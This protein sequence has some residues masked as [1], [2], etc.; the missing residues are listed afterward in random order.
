[1]NI[2]LRYGKRGLPLTLASEWNAIIIRKPVMPVLDDPSLAVRTA[3]TQPVGSG[4]IAEEGVGC[5]T[6]CIAV[7]DITRPVPNS[8]FL[9]HLLRELIAVG[10]KPQN[11]LLLIATGLHRPS[12]PA[13]LAQIIGD[14]WILDTFPIADHYARRDED[15]VLLGVTSRGTPT[16]ID[17]R[18]VE[19]DL[20]IVTGLVEPHLMAGY[21]GGRKVISPGLCHADTI[22]AL[23][24]A[25][26]MG[27]PKSA[28]CIL[29]DNPLHQDQLEILAMVGKTL[30]INTVIDEE[31]RL[32]LVNF[33]E[34]QTSHH[35]AVEYMRPYAEVPV[36]RKFHT[37]VTTTAGYPL[38]CN[39]YQ[40]PKG[41]TAGA[42]I[43]APGGTLLVASE[44][45]EGLG[46][47]EFIAA[48][49]R[50]SEQGREAFLRDIM[51]K[52]RADI[53]EWGTQMIL[54]AV[55][56]GK[57]GLYSDQLSDEDMS[58]TGAFRVTSME[59]AIQES[60][61]ASGD[62]HVAIIPEGPYVVPMV[63]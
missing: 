43:L 13:E 47:E 54:K 53:D 55:Q 34:A 59:S 52:P 61:D 58:L 28:L 23:H 26:L 8:L 6:A 49:R 48:Q 27:H 60:I 41:I 1:M 32:S 15:H 33:G 63:L 16:R 4:T 45:I 30:A 31:R 21:S 40:T 24:R 17:K 20:R 14:P 7:C 18:F 44:C 62:P 29:Q 12:T 36:D 46:S 57:I 9:P 10:L 25:E 19:A 38:D 5:Q 39:Y 3:L 22:C 51:A 50:L 2:T 42:N 56:T 11:I 35:V 37:V